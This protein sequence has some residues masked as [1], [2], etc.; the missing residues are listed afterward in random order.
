MADRLCPVEVPALIAS[1]FALRRCSD[2]QCQKSGMRTRNEPFDRFENT[3]PI[4]AVGVRATRKPRSL[5]STRILRG[6][7]NSKPKRSEAAVVQL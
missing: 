3:T 6:V 2:R 4:I 1:D 7:P 5:A